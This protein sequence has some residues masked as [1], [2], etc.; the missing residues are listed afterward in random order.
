MKQCGE[1][2]EIAAEAPERMLP[3]LDSMGFHDYQMIDG[4]KTV[5]L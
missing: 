5:Y 1:R 3:L 2:I 4:E